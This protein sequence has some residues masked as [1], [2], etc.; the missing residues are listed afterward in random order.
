MGTAQEQGEIWGARANDWTSCNEPAWND[1]FAA[2]L[3][4]AAVA[5]GTSYLDVGC[6]SG[7]ALVLA[8]ARG[9]VV[10]GLDASEN[11][12]QV[13]RQRLPGAEIAVGEMEALPFADGRFDAVS[14]INSFQFAGNIRQALAEARRVSRRGGSVTM[15]VWGAREHCELL[16]NVMPA[17]FAL[18][19]PPP[20]GAP[21][22]QQLP[23]AE[24]GF[25]EELMRGAG[26]EPVTAS[27]ISPPLSFPDMETA[28]RAILSASARAIRH[29]GE[30]TVRGNV[31]GALTPFARTD[32]SVRLSNRFRLVTARRT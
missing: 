31:T 28:T 23:L 18:L 15:L 25:I 24:Q 26:L 20:S 2:V 27:E 14:G 6:G 8:R 17:I 13:A 10:S 16:S 3:D 5:P 32:G 12:A 22:P 30:A 21:P 1:V 4:Q 7:G 11:L 29:A 9:A 19:P